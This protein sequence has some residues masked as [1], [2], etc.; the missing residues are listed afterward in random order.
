V[1]LHRNPVFLNH[2][3]FNGRWPLRE[4]GLTKMDYS[5]HQTPEAEAILQTGVRIAIHEAMTEE[6]IGNVA[7]GI[8]KV[9]RFYA[10]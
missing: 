4:F 2:A 5:K 6:Y 8:I 1:P 10:A 9:A 3:F 7:E